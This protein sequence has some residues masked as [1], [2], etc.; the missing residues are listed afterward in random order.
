MVIC[1][2]WRVFTEPVIINKLKVLI[3]VKL[4]LYNKHYDIIQALLVS[5]LKCIG[6]RSYVNQIVYA[7]LHGNL[8]CTNNLYKLHACTCSV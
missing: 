5:N 6:V 2:Q 1:K 3:N 8:F 4:H 7:V